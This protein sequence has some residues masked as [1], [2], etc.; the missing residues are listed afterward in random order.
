MWLQRVVFTIDISVNVG[1]YKK[2]IP[3]GNGLF[4]L[5][6]PYI[7]SAVIRRRK[8]KW[9][10]V[11]CVNERLVW[12]SPG[13][14]KM[15]KEENS[16]ISQVLIDI[17]LKI[18]LCEEIEE[19]Q[20][21]LARIEPVMVLVE[22]NKT[23]HWIG[24]KII[25]DLREEGRLIPIMVISVSN[26]SDEAVLAF[27]SGGNDYM[28]RPLHVGEFKCRI[29]NLLELTGKRRGLGNL[30]KIDGLILDPGHRYVSRDGNE[31]KV[32]PKEFEL[33]YFLADHLGHICS[34]DEILKK[35]WGYNFETNTNVVDVYIRH[36]RAKVD[37]GYRDKLIH[38]VRGTGYVMRAPMSTP[39]A[40]P[41]ALS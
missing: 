14:K 2:T 24:W 15:Y 35:I 13:R 3:G 39:H 26:S 10:W 41:N 34:R 6:E 36:L 32:T 37:K 17:G 22:L 7:Y 5:R 38:T 12:Y 27:E 29:L 19:L 11:K 23:S 4:V 16:V 31:L 8:A 20:N 21:I 18:T 1:S 25:A 9:M 28:S 33:L 40:D 30:I